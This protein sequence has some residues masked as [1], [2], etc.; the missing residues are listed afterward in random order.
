MFAEPSPAG[1]KYAA[2]LLG[3]C[4]E[5]CRLPVM[6]L[7]EATRERIRSAMQQLAERFGDRLVLDEALATVSAVGTGCN[8]V[9]R[10]SAELR[11]G[12]LDVGVRHGLR[13]RMGLHAFLI[14]IDLAGGGNGRRPQNA[15]TRGKIER[16]ADATGVHQLNEKLGT[17]GVRGGD[18]L[19]DQV[20]ID[21]AVGGLHLILQ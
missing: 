2:S 12:G 7:S 3:F 16:M 6:P 10:R 14:G 18:D 19:I 17:T 20:V 9:A 15:G 5:E 13:R 11:N 21:E 4:S 1:A 8:G